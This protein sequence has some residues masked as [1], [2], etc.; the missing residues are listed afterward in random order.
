MTQTFLYYC[1]TLLLDSFFDT[2]FNLLQSF[3]ACLCS[4]PTLVRK[5]KVV[6]RH[7]DCQSLQP[8]TSPTNF[9]SDL[10]W[11]PD[12]AWWALGSDVRR[13]LIG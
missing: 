3:L 2:F 9:V 1:G 10:R 8:R 13:I 11:G 6:L 4:F 12:Y 5:S 7:H